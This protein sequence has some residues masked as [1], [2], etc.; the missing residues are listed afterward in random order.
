MIILFM[1]LASFISLQGAFLA[2]LFVHL[3]INEYFCRKV[4]IVMYR[5][6]NL[7]L[8]ENC[9]EQDDFKKLQ[10]VGFKS[11]SHQKTII[12]E[13]INSF[14]GDNGSLDGSKMQAN[15]FPQIKAD[16]FISHSHKDENLALALAGWL[17]VT[18]GL[19]VFIDSC[20]WGY[21]ND[22]LRII[23]D[24]NSAA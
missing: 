7:L 23:D 13:K 15:W 1:P 10:E 12:I 17:K 22:L 3:A 2:V 14:V 21:A 19:S 18:F 24:L 4:T 11:I 16:I 5:G 6:F 8:E 20:V 9:F